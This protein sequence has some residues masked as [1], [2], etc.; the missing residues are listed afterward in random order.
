MPDTSLV[1]YDVLRDLTELDELRPT[2]LFAALRAR[3]LTDDLRQLLEEIVRVGTKAEAVSATR[4][5]CGYRVAHVEEFPVD[6]RPRVKAT[7]D[8]ASGDLWYWVPRNP[9]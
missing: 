4:A 5:L 1:A 3:E 2:V 8:R 6:E 9:S 7:A